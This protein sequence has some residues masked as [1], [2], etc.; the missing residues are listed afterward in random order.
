[1]STAGTLREVF[2]VGIVAIVIPAARIKWLLPRLGANPGTEA[3]AVQIVLPGKVAMKP[4]AGILGAPSGYSGGP[5]LVGVLRYPES[6]PDAGACTPF[7]QNKKRAMLQFC[8][9]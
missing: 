8:V 9:C 6:M 1:M 7:P 3:E 2:C 5:R 4:R